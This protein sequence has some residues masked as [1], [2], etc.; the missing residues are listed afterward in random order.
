MK[1]TKTRL[2]AVLLALVLVLTSL[3]LTAMAT[4]DT[5]DNWSTLR[6]EDVTDTLS[7]EDRK[8]MFEENMDPAKVSE[9][10]LPSPD[11]IVSVIVELDADSLLDVRDRVNSAMSMMDF[12]RTQA[13]KD[14][15]SEIA[16]MEASVKEAI[17]AEGITPE[18]V[19]SYAAIISGFSAEV[20]YRDIEAI[21][22]VDGVARVVLCETYYPDVM[23][24]ATLGEALSA[25]EVAAYSNNTDY[26]GEGMLIGILDTGLDTN[27]EAFANAPAVQKLQKSALEKLL[28]TTEE[29]DGKINVTAYSYAALWYA[30]NKST[31]TTKYGNDHGTHVAGIAAGKAVD[32]DGNVTFA[33]QA[34]E[35]QLAIFKVF[36]DSTSGAS[37]DKLLAA[38]ND[39]LLLDVDVINMSLGS[40]GGFSREEDTSAVAKYYDLVKASGILLNTSAGNSYSSS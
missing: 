32:A 13:A 6:V 9:S 26:Q 20:P 25:A 5:R 1:R 37:T 19:F 22:A 28:Y 16:T 34:P 10:E 39:A 29:V 33:G 35:A 27:H 12:Q 2:L 7:D 38:L 3:P 18:Y 24:D 17:E 14:Q 31:S 15:L 8:S 4:P 36:S 21:E 30:Q 23:G 11:D 40:G